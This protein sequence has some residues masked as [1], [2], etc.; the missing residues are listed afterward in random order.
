MIIQPLMAFLGDLS[1]FRA[2][3]TAFDAPLRLWLRTSCHL[4]RSFFNDV[5]PAQAAIYSMH[6]LSLCRSQCRLKP[7]LVH[8]VGPIPPKGGT[9]KAVLLT[10]DAKNA[11]LGA[12]K[13]TVTK[14]IVAAA[15]KLKIANFGYS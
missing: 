15:N 3:L 2:V 10:T 7:E 6:V 1:L 4:V 8:F 11:P 12:R 5:A 9:I 14:S 13:I